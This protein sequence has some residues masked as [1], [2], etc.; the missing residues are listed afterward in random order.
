[1][2]TKF[3]VHRLPVLR[4][5]ALIPSLIELC[6]RS[7]VVVSVRFITRKLASEEVLNEYN[8]RK[9]FGPKM[10][11][12]DRPTTPLTALDFVP[13]RLPNINNLLRIFRA[14]PVSA[15]IPERAFS[16]MKLLQEP[17]A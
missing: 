8:Q 14:L 1:M 7:D 16:A 2:R 3:A 6:E 12:E 11:K 4:L 15:C 17:L 5:I 9:V 13:S 10:K